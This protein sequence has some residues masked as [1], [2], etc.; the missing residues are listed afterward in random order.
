MRL[1][2]HVAV[3]IPRT[4][5]QLGFARASL[6]PSITCKVFSN[7][8]HA[9]HSACDQL[10]PRIRDTSSQSNV[11]PPRKLLG[12]YPTLRSIW[13]LAAG[14]TTPTRGEAG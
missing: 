9:A 1:Q 6:P 10:T 3:G 14:R 4:G 8:G 13:L 12:K 7:Y 5:T 11:R 2:V